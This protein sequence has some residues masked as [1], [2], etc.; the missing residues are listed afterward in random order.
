M[1]P[2]YTPLTPPTT[3]FSLAHMPGLAEGDS[4]GGVD[5]DVDVVVAAAGHAPQDFLHL[6]L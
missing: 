5:V 4:D 6:S 3:E 1:A 2:T